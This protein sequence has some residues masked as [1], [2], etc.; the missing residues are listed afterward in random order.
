[1]VFVDKIINPDD[2]ENIFQFNVK[3]Q[4][5]LINNTNKS[6]TKVQLTRSMVK[7]TYINS[8][9]DLFFDLDKTLFVNSTDSINYYPTDSILIIINGSSPA[10]R[11]RI[12]ERRIITDRKLNERLER[13][14]LQRLEKIIKSRLRKMKEIQLEEKA[15]MLYKAQWNILSQMGYKDRL[16]YFD[17]KR[18][19]REHLK[20]KQ[21]EINK[22]LGL[23]VFHESPNFNRSKK[24]RQK[25]LRYLSHK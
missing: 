15:D 2:I 4:T 12:A 3:N 21:R 24:Y 20:E 16:D 10:K 18:R 19:Q 17:S 7:V 8:N 22:K 9:K 11:E 13:T 6:K 5:F 1:M 25:K 23:P 14:D